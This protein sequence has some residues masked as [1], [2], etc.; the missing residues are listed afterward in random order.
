MTQYKPNMS[1]KRVA[2]GFALAGERSRFD[3]QGQL[4]VTPSDPQGP[5]VE[6]RPR[7]FESFNTVDLIE[8]IDP[9]QYQGT[10][11]GKA[12]D[13]PR[14]EAWFHDDRTR[15]YSFGGGAPVMPRRWTPTLNRLRGLVQDVTGE[16]FDACFVN[17]YRSGKDSID[18]HADDARWIGPVIA[19]VSLGVARRFLMKRKD[20]TGETYQYD[21]GH[22]DL[23]VMLAGC[24]DEWIHSVRKTSRTV[25]VRLNATFRQT[26][27]R[28]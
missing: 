1:K 28:R 9:S 13:R 26:R 15:G 5:P 22:G 23:L 18:W 24:Q 19:S 2:R 17:V 3:V 16:L 12:Y 25:G 10:T 14:L 20:K 7:W 11:Y 6:Y 27:G 4:F 21:L 8:E